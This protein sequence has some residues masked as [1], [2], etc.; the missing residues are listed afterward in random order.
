MR[1][2]DLTGVKFGRLT[3]IGRA[4][5]AGKKV[6][7]R[8]ACDCGGEA[9]LR[10]DKI[11]G[12]R[13]K[14]CGCLMNGR[15][16]RGW[17]RRRDLTGKRFGR[18]TVAGPSGLASN[19]AFTWHCVC[20][21]GAERDVRTGNLRS[22]T[23]QSCG[24]LQKDR[25]VERHF[26]H[27]AKATDKPDLAVTWM[28]M[29]QRCLNPNSTN[30]HLY[31]GRGITICDRWLHGEGGRTGLECFIEDMGPK[32]SPEH[33]VDRHPDND[34]PYAPWNCR[35]A[36]MAEQNLNK[37]SNGVKAPVQPVERAASWL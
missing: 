8:C 29:R 20:D 27:G 36:T 4:E 26:R 21:C 32:P 23:T 5:H 2:L 37:R 18:L 11:T 15:K 17:N 12:R 14:S 22:G 3:V 30:F 7:W 25:T 28:G 34:G 13:T 1:A 24:C 6:V 9:L 33:T 10:T 19:G 35:W 31:G 16:P